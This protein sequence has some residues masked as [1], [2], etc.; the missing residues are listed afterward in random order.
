MIEQA[1]PGINF[2]KIDTA[3]LPVR[4]IISGKERYLLLLETQINSNK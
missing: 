3:A 2:V 4:S 1:F